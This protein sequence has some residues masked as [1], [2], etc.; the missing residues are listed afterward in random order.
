[1]I[2]CLETKMSERR[3]IEVEVEDVSKPG[4]TMNVLVTTYPVEKKTLIIKV[5]GSEPKAGELTNPEAPKAKPRRP[6]K[7][8]LR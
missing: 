6:T 7:E 1:M 3:T 5:R 4:R 8:G 2:E